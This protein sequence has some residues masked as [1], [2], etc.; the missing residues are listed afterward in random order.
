[1][2]CTDARAFGHRPLGGS[3]DGLMASQAAA[4]SR[5]V[6]LI[7][8]GSGAIGSAICRQL[9][10]PSSVIA[11]HWHRNQ[12]RAQEVVSEVV[13]RDGTAAAYSADLTMTAGATDL[14]SRVVTE[15]G[16][17]DVLINGIGMTKDS[18]LL[19][20]DDTDLDTVL[21]VNLKSAFRLTRAVAQYMV[22]QRRG[23]IINISSA[24]ASRPRRGHAHYVASKAGLEGF[25]RAMAVELAPKGIRVNA[26]APGIIASD[27]TRE[28]RLRMGPRLLQEIPL[29]RFGTPTEVAA[30][31][32]FLASA[33]AAYITGQVL[34][35]DGGRC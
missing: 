5:D 17:I 13:D 26:V 15:W 1:M 9:A 19:E 18:L 6:I 31:V 21:D 33:D 12:E 3:C 25:T 16:G 29:R 24:A 2:K 32:R 28:L 8:G 27:I 23:V 4:T 14:V 22:R 10:G 35:V 34:H 11:V 30:A 20:L 7:S